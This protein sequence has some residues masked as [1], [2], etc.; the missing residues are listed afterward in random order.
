MSAIGSTGVSPIDAPLSLIEDAGRI[1]DDTSLRGKYTLIFFGLTHCRVVCPRA[2]GKL[3]RVLERLGPLGS[4]VQPLYITVDPERDTPDVLRAF[5][6]EQYPRFS[7]VTGSR[8]QIDN[9]KR[10]FRV[11][12]QRRDE[13][14][15]DYVIPHTAITDVLDPAGRFI[16]HWPDALDED[17][18]VMRLGTLLNGG[19]VPRGQRPLAD[20]R[21]EL[22]S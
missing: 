6:K 2:L 8:E 10:T 14:A 22:G 4:H 12:A 9:A 15:G 7:G 18:L 3:T 16:D 5:L 19:A 20:E 1:V 17:T 21:R 13:G 11:F